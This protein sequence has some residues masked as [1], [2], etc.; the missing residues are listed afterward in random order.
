M[1]QEFKLANS[2][3]KGFSLLFPN[4]VKIL[5]FA[6]NALS[7]KYSTFHHIGVKKINCHNTS[8]YWC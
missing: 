6:N 1:I 4:N 7:G 8:S 5:Y 3:S 2:P